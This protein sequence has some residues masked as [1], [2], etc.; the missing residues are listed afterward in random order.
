MFQNK[1]NLISKNFFL[2][3]ILGTLIILGSFL[4]FNNI[5]ELG[6]KINNANAASLCSDTDSG[7]YPYVQG[8]C[9]D[10]EANVTDFCSGNNLT[11][12]YCSSSTCISKL[13]SCSDG[14]LSGK[15]SY[16]C[17][18]NNQCSGTEG[19]AGPSVCGST[20][21]GTWGITDGDS[22]S[23]CWGANNCCGADEIGRASCRERV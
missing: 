18:D 22:S 6:L 13:Y 2:S 8:T 16:S 11:E 19:D 23:S 15:C 7:D 20:C 12:Y 5:N 21:S 10:I 4:F 14:C 17:G 3:F 1:I 9:S